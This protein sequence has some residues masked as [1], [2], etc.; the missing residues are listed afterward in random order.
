VPKQ[1]STRSAPAKRRSPRKSVAG[2]NS[3][4][5]VDESPSGNGNLSPEGNVTKRAALARQLVLAAWPGIVQGLIKK[6]MSGGC[7]QTKLLLELCDLASMD[8]SDLN[9]E[10]KR[11]LCDALL[12]GLGLSSAQP[13]DQASKVGPPRELEKK[14]PLVS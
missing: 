7:P 4:R 2:V 9:D 11:Q 8:A 14:G 5:G 3:G 6:A 10:R 12:E 13:E 1:C